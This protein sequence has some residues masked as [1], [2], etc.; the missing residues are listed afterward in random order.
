MVWVNPKSDLF[1]GR[2][3]IRLFGVEERNEDDLNAAAWLKKTFYTKS[4]KSLL[5]GD[6]LTIFGVVTYDV[7]TD[8]FNLKN[9]IAFI[10]DS[11]TIKESDIN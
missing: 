9:P 2:H 3:E 8:K 5:E 4:Y 6:T 7:A 11:H 1:F 10:G